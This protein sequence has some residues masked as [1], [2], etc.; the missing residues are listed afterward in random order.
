MKTYHDYVIKD[1]CFIGK[2]DEMYQSVD[3]PW[4]QDQ[5]PNPYARYAGICHIQKFGIRSLVECGSGLGYYSE[6]IYRQTGIIPQGF[7]IS[8]TAVQK[9]KALFPHL[10]FT[11]DTVQN[12]AAYKDLDAIL[13]AEIT[14]YVLPDLNNLFALM[15]EH[16]ANKYLIHNLVFYKGTQQYGTEYFTNLQEFIKFVPFK[17]V[18]YCEATTD[19]ESTIETS[20]IFK[21]E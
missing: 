4:M 17:L 14:W 20:T 10:N 15:K 21:I 2:F 19:Q 13:F 3:Q 9:A 6:A 5:Q 8:E 16:F 18:G 11:V 7:D 1:G 12:L